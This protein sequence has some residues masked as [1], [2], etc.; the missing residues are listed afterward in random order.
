M[1]I[2]VQITMIVLVIVLS[3]SGYAITHVASRFSDWLASLMCFLGAAFIAYGLYIQ[4]DGMAVFYRCG[5]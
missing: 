4:C 5:G 2:A 1:D 3:I